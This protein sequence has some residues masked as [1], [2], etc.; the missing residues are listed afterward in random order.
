MILLRGPLFSPFSQNRQVVDRSGLSLPPQGPQCQETVIENTIHL[1]NI[2]NTYSKL[3]IAQYAN[4]P[5][6]IFDIVG[7]GARKFCSSEAAGAPD[8]INTGALSL[9]VLKVTSL[10]VLGGGGKTAS[11]NQPG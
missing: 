6:C 1:G 9:P 5:L 3:L 7:P 2:C 10:A 4:L 11:G 8:E